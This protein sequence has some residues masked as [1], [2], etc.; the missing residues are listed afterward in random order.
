MSDALIEVLVRRER[1]LSRVAQQ[2][3]G[4]VLAVA[5][6]QR[7]IALVDRLAQAGRVLR[8]HPAAVVILLAGV[9]ALRARTLIGMVG[10]GIALWRTLRSLRALIG[11][12]AH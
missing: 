6:L 12:F 3:D 2:R 1:I 11:H 10:R 9:F 4:M 8:A 7:P 5:R